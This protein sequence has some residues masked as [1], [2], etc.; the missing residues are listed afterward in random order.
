MTEIIGCG[1]G[2]WTLVMKVNGDKVKI[3]LYTEIVL[4]KKHRK[5]RD[6]QYD[7][8]LIITSIPD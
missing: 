3:N 4:V 5:T 1:L 7:D 6:H 2:G 8:V